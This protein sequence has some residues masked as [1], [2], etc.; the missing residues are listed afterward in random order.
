VDEDRP[1]QITDAELVFG[2]QPA[3]PVVSSVAPHP[4]GRIASKPDC[5]VAS[6]REIFPSFDRALLAPHIDRGNL[7]YSR[8]YEQLKQN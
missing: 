5:A 3:V 2:D 7:A 4:G 8:E 1:N 6:H